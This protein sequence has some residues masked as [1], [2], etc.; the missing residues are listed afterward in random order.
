VFEGEAQLRDVLRGNRPEFPADR[1]PTRRELYEQSLI[2]TEGERFESARGDFE[3]TEGAADTLADRTDSITGDARAQNE[4]LYDEAL[5]AGD[6]YFG[7]AQGAADDS[8]ART[9]EYLDES[10]D[11]VWDMAVREKDMAV[12]D[13]RD[14]FASSVSSLMSLRADAIAEAYALRSTTLDRARNAIKATAHNAAERE[15]SFWANQGATPHEIEGARRRV[16]LGYG[17]EMGAALGE[18]MAASNRSIMEQRTAYDSLVSNMRTTFGSVFGD[19]RTTLGRGVS[20]DLTQLTINTQ[21]QRRQAEDAYSQMTTAIQTAHADFLGRA[22]S[23]RIEYDAII[24]QLELSGYTSVAEILRALQ[25]PFQ[26]WSGVFGTIYAT[27]PGYGGPV[28]A[29]SGRG[30]GGI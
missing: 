23:S 14:V 25:E 13:L 20:S 4:R 1:P 24:D 21:A 10:T 26:N 18:A 8:L 11:Q 28:A 7:Q 9:T 6:E 15:A 2:D 3:R 27:G 5:G 22:Q 17:D 30:P 12:Q 29:T 16:L 19:A